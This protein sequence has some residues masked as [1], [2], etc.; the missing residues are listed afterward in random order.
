MKIVL[1]PSILDHGTFFYWVAY[2]DVRVGAIF[3]KR[4]FAHLPFEM[5][6]E[7][8]KEAVRIDIK[9]FFTLQKIT[10]RLTK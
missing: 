7:N 4:F 6:D 2:N 9:N 8:D 3:N 10:T 5:L 1:T